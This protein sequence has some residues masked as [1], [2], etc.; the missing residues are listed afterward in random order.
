M[1]ILKTLLLTLF[2]CADAMA[3]ENQA[4]GGGSIFSGSFAESLW[5]VIAFVVLVLVLGKFAWKP[6]LKALKDR[7][8]HIK[9]QIE[10]A[11]HAHKQAEKM[12]EEIEQRRLQILQDAA[13][14][15]QKHEQ[16]SAE[17]ARKKASEMRQQATQDI[18][19]AHAAAEDRLWEQA[20]DIM[21]VLGKQVLGRTIADEDNQ[22]LIHDAIN[23][24]KK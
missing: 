16:E 22:R 8:E 19:R 24:L 15:A 10:A 18:E 11:E 21:L 3:A 4:Q 6:M 12:R 5:T 13:D 23:E 17:T 14:R 7:Q 1:K 9:G 20:G 2:I